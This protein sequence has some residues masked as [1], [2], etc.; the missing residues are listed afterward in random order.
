MFGPSKPYKRVILQDSWL[1]F[2]ERDV[3]RA[4]R[5]DRRNGRI[6][7]RLRKY[8]GLTPFFHAK[9]ATTAV[10]T[11]MA[12]TCN[13]GLVCRQL[14]D[15]AVIDAC[16]QLHSPFL[17]DLAPEFWEQAAATSTVGVFSKVFYAEQDGCIVHNGKL[18]VVELT[19]DQP[20]LDWLSLGGMML[21]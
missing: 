11:A 9:L 2:S 18:A 4:I 16:I 8:F 12:V 17:R 19:E 3:Q 13:L 10:D 15:N 6:P 1:D 21:D 7:R 20:T 14:A 5:N